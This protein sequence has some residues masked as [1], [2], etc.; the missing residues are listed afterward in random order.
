VTLW[1]K[2]AALKVQYSEAGLE[3][4]WRRS[5]GYVLVW[6]LCMVVGGF[7]FWN[8]TSFPVLG[9]LVWG[10]SAVL[11]PYYWAVRTEYR[12]ERQSNQLEVVSHYLLR[13]RTLRYPLHS[14]E[15][16]TFEEVIGA[17]TEGDPN[18]LMYT[19]SLYLKDGSVVSLT[20]TSDFQAGK[21]ELAE[22]L[23]QGLR[24]LRGYP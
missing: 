23:E 4:V 22:L 20:D 2:S 8:I 7:W 21:R 12:L 3:L 18:P 24:E 1:T 5:G 9:Y 17:S 13:R 19:V 10:T 11:M 16:V 14:L 6:V 15:H